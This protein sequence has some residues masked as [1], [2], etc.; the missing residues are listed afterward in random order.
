MLLR[1]WLS[2]LAAVAIVGIPALRFPC[3]PQNQPTRRLR[4]WELTRP[5]ILCQCR[6]GTSDADYI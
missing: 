2:R 3:Q 6:K 1:S 4:A 5:W